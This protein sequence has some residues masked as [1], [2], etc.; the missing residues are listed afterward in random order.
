MLRWIFTRKCAALTC[1]IDANATGGYDVCV[2]PHWDVSSA[3]IERFDGATS[4]LQRH[5]ELARCLREAGWQLAKRMT[6]DRVR[7]AA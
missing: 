7:A 2:V 1:E 6:A 5:A 4:A 3:A